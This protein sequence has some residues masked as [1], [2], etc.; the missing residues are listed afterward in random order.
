MKLGITAKL[1]L[2]ILAACVAVLLINGIAVQAFVK[3][4]FLDYL[5]EQGVER[6]QETL[7]R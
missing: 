4:Q 6:M 3:R 5:N 7:P 1:F 2:A